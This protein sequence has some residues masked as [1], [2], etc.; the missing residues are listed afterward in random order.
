M[1]L[2]NEMLKNLERRNGQKTGPYNVKSQTNEEESSLPLMIWIGAVVACIVLLS[3]VGVHYY[4]KYRA[5]H[6]HLAEQLA[7]PPAT[8]ITSTP[9]AAPATKAPIPAHAVTV[10][11]MHINDLANQTSVVFDLDTTANFTTQ[12]DLTNHTETISIKNAWLDTDSLCQQL[13]QKSDCLTDNNIPLPVNTASIKSIHVNQNDG[14]TLTFLFKLSDDAKLLNTNLK[15]NTLTITFTNNGQA[16][17]NDTDS[18]VLKT[19]QPLPIPSDLTTDT[20]TDGSSILEPVSESQKPLTLYDKIDTYILLKQYDKAEEA[21]HSLSAEEKSSASG[22]L[23]Q[24]RFELALGNNPQ[25]LAILNKYPFNKKNPTPEFYA[26]YAATLEFNGKHSE[27]VNIYKNLVKQ[28]P[29][30]PTWL[31]G[32]AI[33]ALND[34]QYDLAKNAF[35]TL[36][37]IKDLN[38]EITNYAKQQIEKINIENQ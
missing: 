13:V 9:A 36:T 33:A 26:L 37:D 8:A 22:L 5:K 19:A 2:I 30:N 6:K 4:E 18:S 12:A 29:E 11:K 23:L 21:I 20:P 25:A 17:N 3:T 1:S 15:D 16:Q 24:A 28:S 32:F 27:A 10:S 38:P 31:L 7:T 34:H 14:N 35:Q